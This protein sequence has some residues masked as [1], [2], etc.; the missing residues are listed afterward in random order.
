M[1]RE[2]LVAVAD[3][4]EELETIAIVDVLRRT[5]ANVIIAA[6][7]DIQITA[8]KGVRLAADRAISPRV[9]G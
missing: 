8:S 1:K 7:G 5:G 9:S 3:G 2:V 4:S 6:I